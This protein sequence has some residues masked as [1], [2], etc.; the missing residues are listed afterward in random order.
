MV[1]VAVG[2]TV[3]V[4]VGGMIGV[5]VGGTVGVGVGGMIGV[6]VGGTVG[7]AV[8]GMVGVAVG[9]T[10][11]VAVGGIVGVAVGGTVGVAVGGIVGVAVGGMVGVAV[12]VGVGVAV[13]GVVGV[14]VS[15]GVGVAV[16]G[17]VGVGVASVTTMR[18]AASQYT[19][20]CLVGKSGADQVKTVALLPFTF[21]ST[22]KNDQA[23]NGCCSGDQ[24]ID[25]DHGS[26]P[27][28]GSMPMRMCIGLGPSE[29]LG[30]SPFPDQAWPQIVN[31]T[32]L[33]GAIPF[34]VW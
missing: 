30:S 12:S 3:G 9:G 11:G 28:L 25:P 18:E 22:T 19:S 26:V 31:L 6:A 23:S 4:G 32:V 10:V 7:V 27:P 34:T 13:G 5:A 24:T 1:G 2:G 33:P 15:V 14:A 20:L 29:M 17:V 16:G 21:A 8:G